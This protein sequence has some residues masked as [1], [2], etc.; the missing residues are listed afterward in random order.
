MGRIQILFLAAVI[1][2]MTFSTTSIAQQMIT[3]SDNQRVNRAGLMLSSD[4]KLNIGG[5]GQIDYNQPF[6]NGT[7]YQGKLDV[8][9]LVILFGYRFTNKLS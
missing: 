2:L 4:R 6:G 7:K 5:Y 1:F 3:N 8:H 9:R